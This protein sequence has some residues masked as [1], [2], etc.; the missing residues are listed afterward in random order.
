MC[1]AAWAAAHDI[2]MKRPTVLYTYAIATTSEPIFY[3]LHEDGSAS[4]SVRPG[5]AWE[6][7]TG[8][9]FEIGSPAVVAFERGAFEGGNVVE[10][11][12]SVLGPQP[13]ALSPQPRPTS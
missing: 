6:P 13:S 12:V 5:G 4:A 3:A 11:A 2:S 8:A 10:N 9:F 7:C 1:G